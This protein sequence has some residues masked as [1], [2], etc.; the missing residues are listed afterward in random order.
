M[1]FM[2]FASDNKTQ[3]KKKKKMQIW[4]TS[5]CAARVWLS[6]VWVLDSRLDTKPC[7][8][9]KMVYGSVICA[10]CVLCGVRSPDWSDNRP[11]ISHTLHLFAIYYYFMRSAVW[12]DTFGLF[13]FLCAVR[14]CAVL[15]VINP[16]IFYVLHFASFCN[17][18][19]EMC[20]NE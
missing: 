1:P 11:I 4:Q 18:S 9:I 12:T 10:S 15:P 19:I 8:W 16:N 17:R 5:V 7:V 20:D 3:I 6:M 2:D 13:F 14:R